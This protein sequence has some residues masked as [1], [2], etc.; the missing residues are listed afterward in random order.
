MCIVECNQFCMW[1]CLDAQVK[2]YFMPDGI[3]KLISQWIS[4]TCSSLPKDLLRIEMFFEKQK[5]TAGTDLY[6]LDL[7]YCYAK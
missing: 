3:I 6:H 7:S 5:L 1:H 4:Q 2:P